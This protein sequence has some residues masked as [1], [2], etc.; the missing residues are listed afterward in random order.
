MKELVVPSYNESP[1]TRITLTTELVTMSGADVV[2]LAATDRSRISLITVRNVVVNLVVVDV[3]TTVLWTVVFPAYF[4]GRLFYC[5][6]WLAFLHVLFQPVFL[7]VEYGVLA[8]FHSFTFET[9][10]RLVVMLFVE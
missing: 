6:F 4:S 10:H 7:G 8:L 5:I 9:D 3:T 2:V 1:W